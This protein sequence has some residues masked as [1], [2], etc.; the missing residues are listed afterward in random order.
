MID[1][2][3]QL[4]KH[5]VSH[6]IPLRNP[7]KHN[8]VH[9]VASNHQKLRLK[10][11]EIDQDSFEFIEQFTKDFTETT[12]PSCPSSIC[13]APGSPVATPEPRAAGS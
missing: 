10:L 13:R 6:N 9:Q 5:D 11:I 4:Q 12:F 3:F 8:Q 2:A 7:P 1:G